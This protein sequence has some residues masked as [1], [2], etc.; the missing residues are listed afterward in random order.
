MNKFNKN[1]N[2]R[3]KDFKLIRRLLLQDSFYDLEDFLNYLK[4]T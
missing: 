2:T 1:V 4:F 3:K